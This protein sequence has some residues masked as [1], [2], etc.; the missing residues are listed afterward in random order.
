[1]KVRK[2]VMAGL[3]LVALLALP[4]VGNAQAPDPVQMYKDMLAK[5]EAGDIDGALAYYSEDHVSALIPPPPGETGIIRGNDEERARME[6]VYALNPSHEIWDCETSGNTTTCSASYEGDDTRSMGIGPLEFVIEFV[7]EDGL[8]TSDTW[9]MTDETLAAL[10]AV[11][12]ALP[13]TGGAAFPV[14]AVMVGLG[15]LAAAG[16]AILARRRG[17]SG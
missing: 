5:L 1:M 2:M 17:R 3:V 15:G 14:Q 11:M 16:G 12:V 7:V 6:E 9:T 4:L 8:I 13:E 10:T